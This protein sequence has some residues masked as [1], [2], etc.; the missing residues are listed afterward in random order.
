MKIKDI[1]RGMNNI[2]LTAKVVDK[3]ETRN[4]KTKY[5]LRRVASVT[6]EDETGRIKLTLWEDKIDIVNIGDTVQ[7]KG[8]FVTE[9]RG[10]L[11]LNIPR[12]G[13]LIVL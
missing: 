2:S 1:S 8:A 7:V 13:A 4:V 3:S 9:F 10:S 12:T 6:L 5:G 11:Q